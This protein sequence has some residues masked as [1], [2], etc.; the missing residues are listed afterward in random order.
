MH[1]DEAAAAHTITDAI[2]HAA[3][4]LPAQ[5]P[6]GVFIHHNTLHAF[7]HMPFEDAVVKASAIFDAEPFMQEREYRTALS[8][9]RI[10][11]HDVDLVLDN[12][13][14]R[15]DIA[16]TRL[17]SGRAT[18]RALRRALLLNHVELESDASA[19][20][21]VGEGGALAGDA[22][23]PA[24]ASAARFEACHRAAMHTEWP[25][26]PVSPPA[27]IRDLLVAHDPSCDP[28]EL[29]HPLLIRICAAFLDQGVAAWPMPLRER[30]LLHAATP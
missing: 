18:R 24:A 13:F 8:C 6:I 1:S 26:A 25:V 30:G 20:W 7:E 10:R 21:T 22:S 11:E 29:V 15:R 4:L 14:V 2:E 12:D 5:G 17:A 27:R 3:H 9:G 28:D 23:E 19:A 16:D